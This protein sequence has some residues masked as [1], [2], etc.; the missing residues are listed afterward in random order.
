MLI[1]SLIL[2]IGIVSSSILFFIN[3]SNHPAKDLSTGL[4][5]VGNKIV[6][7]NGATL[8]LHGVDYTYFIDNPSGSWMLPSGDT[9]YG[10]WDITALNSNLDAIKNWGFNNIRIL[11]TTQWWIQNTANFQNNLEYFITQA[12]ARGITID[13][14][15]WRNNGTSAQTSLPYPPYD[16]GNRVINSVS[17]FVNLWSNV[18]NAL[19]PFPNVMFELWNEPNGDDAAQASWFNVTQKCIDAIRGTCASNIIVVQWGSCTYL[20]FLNYSETLFSC[21]SAQWALLNSL[22]DPKNNIVYSTHLYSNG[23]Y[24]SIENYTSKFS[25]SD[26]V[27]ALNVTGLLALASEHPLWIGEIGCNLWN[28]NMDNE[29]SWY[30][31]TLTILNQYSIGYSAWAWAPWKTGTPYGLVTGDSNFQPNQAGQILQQKLSR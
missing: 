21:Q 22:H 19:K 24:D 16:S 31:N 9:E 27:W 15:F 30:N 14:T 10:A 3:N 13:F 25:Y 28:S 8:I 5:V 1:L 12:A 18:A 23:F 26:M 7:G 20:D 4:H 2:I 6:T 29:Y 11:T 17:D